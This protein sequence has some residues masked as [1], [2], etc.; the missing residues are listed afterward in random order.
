MARFSEFPVNKERIEIRNENGIHF[1]YFRGVKLP[2]LIESTVTQGAEGFTTA[3]LCFEV[4]LEK[5]KNVFEIKVKDLFN[6]INHKLDMD[7]DKPTI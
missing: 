5:T 7:N 2:F 3:T 4:D 1:A 6:S